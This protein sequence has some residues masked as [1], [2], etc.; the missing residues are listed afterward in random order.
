MTRF[1]LFV[2]FVAAAAAPAQ[3]RKPP[4]ITTESVPPVP[5]EI[6]ERLKQYGEFRSAAFAGWAPD[7]NGMLISTRPHGRKTNLSG[8]HGKI[9][10]TKT[11]DKVE[12]DQKLRCATIRQR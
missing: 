3:N 9:S 1:A 12:T 5:A 4:A 2:L 7:G 11:L 6:S 8:S 10:T